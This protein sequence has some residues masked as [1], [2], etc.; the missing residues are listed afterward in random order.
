[1]YKGS[2]PVKSHRYADCGE[3]CA[4]YSVRLEEIGESLYV[5]VNTNPTPRVVG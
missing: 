3:N 5:Q 2:K 1:M 4:M